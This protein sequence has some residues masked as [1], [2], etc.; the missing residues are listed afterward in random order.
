MQNHIDSIRLQATEL[1]L[2]QHLST[3]VGLLIAESMVC[4]HAIQTKDHNRKLDELTPSL[5]K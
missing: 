1:G 4:E 5:R 2:R 3:R